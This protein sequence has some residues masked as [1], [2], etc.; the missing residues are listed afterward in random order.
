MKKIL[1]SALVV[2]VLLV[3]GLTV[4]IAMQSE[5]FTVTRSQEI[6]ASPNDVH[7]HINDFHKWDAWSPW[8]KIDPA[9]RTSITGPPSGVGAKYAWEGNSEVGKGNMTITDSRP[10]EI[11]K[12]DL[13]FTEPFEATNVTE[14]QLQPAGQGTNV[15]W[16]ISGKKNFLMKAMCLVVDMDT[17]MGPDFEKGLA[18]LK[19]AAENR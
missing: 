5:D 8:A 7:A 1:L 2:I 17:M 12:I 4:L 13:Q 18:Q 10:G 9:M 16:T 15:T 14:F 19:Q 11:V 6:S 3:A